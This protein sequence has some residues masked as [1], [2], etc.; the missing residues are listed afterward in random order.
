MENP[1]KRYLEDAIAA[2]KSFET[3]L[4]GF[5]GEATSPQI[6]AVFLTHADETKVQYDRLTARLHELGG[7]SPG[8]KSALAH[9]FNVAPKAAQIG[10]SK[11]ERAT[12]DLMMAYAVENAEVAMYESLVIACEVFSDADTAA[13]C[14]DIQSQEKATAGKVWKLID[15]T[16]TEAFTRA[17]RSE[18]NPL[19][20]YLEDVEAAERNFEDALAGFSKMGDQPQVRSLMAMMSGKA[21]TQHER[22]AGRLKDLGGSPSAAK[23]VLA[24]LLAFT[25]VSAQMGHTDAEKSTQ[26][27]MITFA[28]ASAEMAMYESLAAV[29]RAGD[30]D[31]T[32]RLAR[33]LQDEEKEDHSLAWEHLTHSAREALSIP[34]A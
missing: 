27:L 10:H 15:P 22:L 21:R 6:Q 14:R 2:E 29:A 26:H 30:D 24:H 3:Q 8:L 4:R 16:A 5:A 17:D 9:L 25:P 19:I 34:V 23:S 1:I 32:E 7:E 31:E 20:P 18:K 28:A 11:E 33:Q 13:L 12:Q